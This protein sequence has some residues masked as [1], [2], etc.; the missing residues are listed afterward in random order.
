MAPE[1]LMSYDVRYFIGDRKIGLIVIDEAHLITTWGR[2][3]RVDYWYLG[4]QIRKI[5]K[6]SEQHFPMIAVTATA[7][8]GGDKND[9]VFDT[10]DSLVMH[11]PHYFIGI[12]KRDDIEFIINNYDSESKGFDGQKLAQTAKFIKDVNGLGFKTL[13][14]APYTGHVRKLSTMANEEEEIAVYYYGSSLD[15][16]SKEHAEKQFRANERNV[17][18]CTKAFG[19]GVDI[20]DIQ[21][22]Y[23][24]APSG[25]LPDYVQEIGRVARKKGIQG[26]ATLNYSQRDQNYS[27]Q[28]HGMSALKLWQLKAVLKKIYDTYQ[29][30]GNKRNMLLSVDD[31]TYA[32][33]DAIDV[34]QKVKTALMMIE[35]DY[36]MKCRYNVVVARPKQL[37]TRVYAKVNAN[38]YDHIQRHYANTFDVIR[39]YTDGTR[40][41]LIDLN[42]LWS[43]YFSDKSFPVLKHQ[44]YNGKLLTGCNV[45]PRMKVTY[46]FKDKDNTIAPI[47]E[48]F[49]LLVRFFIS[50]EYRFFEKE[51]LIA[52]LKEQ[53]D[54]RTA[55]QLANFVLS[56][57]SGER[58]PMGGMVEENA[59]LQ[60]KH[61]IPHQYKVFGTRYEG[62]FAS[63]LS[64]LAKLLDTEDDK[65]VRYVS[66]ENS[67]PYIRIGHLMEILDLGSYE[68]RGGDAPMIFV[69]LNNPE[70]V[71]KDCFD[72]GYSNILFDRTKEKHK[73]SSEIM[74]YF[75]THA[76]SNE[77]RWN[78][79]EDFFLGENNEELIRRYPGREIKRVDVVEVLKGKKV[80]KIDV[81]TVKGMTASGMTY[82]PRSGTYNPKD[83]LT[84]E[85]VGQPVTYTI[86]GWID[87]D[88]LTLHKAVKDRVIYVH[89]G[90]VYHRLMNVIEKDYPEYYTRLLGLRKTLKILGHRE[91]AMAEVIMRKDPVKFYKWWVSHRSE[92]HIPLRDLVWLLDKVEKEEPGAIKKQDTQYVDSHKKKK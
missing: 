23:H 70:R 44:Y 26:Y 61:T 14:Y 72:P 34:D 82:P 48:A 1:L 28:L 63:T 90:S 64:T 6:Y 40:L 27:K 18:I 88:P 24:H 62:S 75:F 87:N 31:F 45:Q 53:Y 8:F 56:T 66:K 74:N 89:A 5:R 76:Y 55:K 51:D 13:V 80:Q 77:E 86:Q 83:H 92:V 4:N 39:T 16:M 32:F 69:R 11:S 91:P 49:D 35:K 43:D 22:V 46:I 58:R 2:D 9:M 78:F 38:S 17:M 37:F 59:F 68:M 41:L 52:A 79:I 81:S 65:A 29:H 7:V 15:A 47:R 67:I 84:L 54:D 25:L 21:V 10:V 33:E 20:P 57:Y 85:V 12:V 36:L 71:R 19:M 30:N 42:K 3:F 60:E 73:V 50:T